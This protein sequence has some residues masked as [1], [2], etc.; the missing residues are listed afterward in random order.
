MQHG[1]EQGIRDL[2]AGYIDDGDPGHFLAPREI[3]HNFRPP[4]LSGLLDPGIEVK[5]LLEVHIDEVIATYHP[6]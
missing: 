2:V 3:L 5:P 1:G 4:L 6:V